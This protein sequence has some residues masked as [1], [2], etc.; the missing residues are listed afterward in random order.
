MCSNHSLISCVMAVMLIACQGKETV[1]TREAAM[2]HNTV[3]RLIETIRDQQ[4]ELPQ[5]LGA[6]RDLRNLNDVSAV[7]E[8]KALLGRDRPGPD[9]ATV[10]WDPAAAERVVDLHIVWTLYALGDDAELGRIAAL[11]AQAGRILAGP[12]DECDNAARVIE[13]IGRPDLVRQI[14]ELTGSSEASVSANAVSVLRKLDLPGA[15]IGGP[16]ESIPNLSEEVSFEIST[17]KE[18]ME[19]IA[20][21]SRGSIQLTSGVSE[22]IAAHDYDR[23]TVGRENMTLA[24]IVEGDLEALGF[25]YFVDRGRVFIC[26]HAEAARRWQ[27][28]WRANGDRLRYDELKQEFVLAGEQ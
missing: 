5:R 11:V 15:P 28:W 7:A 14:I 10:N 9:Q 20:E 13:G 25:D 21:L 23:G 26:T 16:V 17:L 3:N 19:T 1:D 4:G 8:L 12:D 22:Y 24:E 2:A 18:E 6:L 27:D